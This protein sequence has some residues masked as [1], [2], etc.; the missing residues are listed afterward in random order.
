MKKISDDKL[1][2]ISGGLLANLIWLGVAGAG[3]YS[4]GYFF[5]QYRNRK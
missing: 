1:F 3:G 2:N 5:K 4:I